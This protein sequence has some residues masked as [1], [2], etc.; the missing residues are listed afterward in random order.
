MKDQADLNDRARAA[1][2]VGTLQAGYTDFHYL[3]PEWKANTEK[4]ALVGVG[5]TGIASG[6]VLP[7]DLAEAAEVVKEENARVAKI[8]GINKAAR[9]TTV[10]PSGTSSLV[11]GTSSGIHAWHN[12]YYIRRMRMGKDEALYKY[13]SEAHPELVEEETFRP[14]TMAVV[15]VPQEAPKNAIIRTES[16]T[17]LLDRVS[18]FN[19]EWVRSG[20]RNGKNA[21]NVSC[22]ISVQDSEWE[23]VGQWM[24][25]K[26]DEYNGIAVLPYMGGSYPQMPF[27][28]ITKQEFDEMA[29]DMRSINLTNVIEEEDNTDLAGEI[30]CGSGGCEVT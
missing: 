8:I 17:D 28:D 10:K 15:G 29:A 24:W 25:D 1:A 23:M 13:L 27:E 12:D 16:P 19:T 3:N 20:H 18:R 7:L 5:M 30:A 2:F 6:A 4:D 21:H 9:T 11:L 22:T 26:R 14:E